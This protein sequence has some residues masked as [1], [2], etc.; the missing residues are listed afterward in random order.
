MLRRQGIYG[1]GSGF[2]SLEEGSDQFLYGIDSFA[3]AP[4]Q[5]NYLI[6]ASTLLHSTKRPLTSDNGIDLILTKLLSLGAIIR[7]TVP[8]ATSV[9]EYS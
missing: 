2:Q 9:Y 4:A 3:A 6:Y 5:Q 1:A 7:A 8:R